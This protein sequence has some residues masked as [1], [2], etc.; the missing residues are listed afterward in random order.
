MTC[1]IDFGERASL[2][3]PLSVVGGS[4]FFYVPLFLLRFP[5]AVSGSSH[6][7]EFGLFPFFFFV[8]G[9]APSVGSVL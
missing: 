2:R 7:W 9:K 4:S 1:A 3:G 8:E 5:T 6:A